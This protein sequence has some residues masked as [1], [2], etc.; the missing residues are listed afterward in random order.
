MSGPAPRQAGTSS[1]TRLRMWVWQARCARLA[2]ARG[3]GPR[4]APP[5]S[6]HK[7]NCGVMPQRKHILRCG[8]YF[9]QDAGYRIVGALAH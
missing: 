6:T 4:A 3:V 7:K 1:P 5:G 2:A 9:S 8:S